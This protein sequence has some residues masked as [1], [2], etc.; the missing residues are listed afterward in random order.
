MRE[1]PRRPSTSSPRAGV[2]GRSREREQ[3]TRAGE[4]A[5]SGCRQ[6]VQPGAEPRGRP[7]AGKPRS[8]LGEAAATTAGAS[9]G[10]PSRVAGAGRESRARKLHLAQGSRESPKRPRSA[11]SRVGP[12]ADGLGVREPRA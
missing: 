4:E 3:E 1:S 8:A 6:S 11:R 2:C 7:V 5:R 10:F 12:E 9:P